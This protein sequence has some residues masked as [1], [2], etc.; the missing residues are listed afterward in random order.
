MSVQRSLP[1]S[2]EMAEGSENSLL[3]SEKKKG[4]NSPKKSS[5]NVNMSSSNSAQQKSDSA[6]GYDNNGLL[7]KLGAVYKDLN[8]SSTPF[9]QGSIYASSSRSAS[10]GVG[11]SGSA[12]DIDGSGQDG[13]S[14]NKRNQDNAAHMTEAKIAME[15]A[16]K[17]KKFAEEAQAQVDAIMKR[18]AGV[19][20]DSN[21]SSSS[22]NRN[23]M[24]KVSAKTAIVKENDIS[25]SQSRRGETDTLSKHKSKKRQQPTTAS[26]ESSKVKRKRYTWSDALHRKFMG[27]IFDI[28][29]RCA[30]PKLLL[31]ILQ[32]CP[33]GLTTEHIKSHLQKYRANSKK[34]RDM[35]YAQYEVAKDQAVKSHEGKALNPGFHAY[36]MPVGE[37]P[38]ITKDKVDSR[39][40]KNADDENDNPRYGWVYYPERKSDQSSQPR[41]ENYSSNDRGKKNERNVIDPQQKWRNAKQHQKGEGTDQT[42]DLFKQVKQMEDQVQMH[43]QIQ[44]RHRL[45]QHH[46]DPN[47]SFAESNNLRGERNP[48]Q[49]GS[50]H[51]SSSFIDP[52]LALRRNSLDILPEYEYLLSPL[53]SRSGH[54]EE[55]SQLLEE[56][57]NLF[58]FLEDI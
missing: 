52:Y 33:D 22:N 23:H 46:Y 56:D 25:Q 39:E 3:S 54:D 37:Y 50:G 5:K 36:P 4:S 57:N 20:T 13:M 49:S 21:V 12:R 15:V 2:Q 17:A 18:A 48:S 51:A 53:A 45:Q 24:G 19:N 14:G 7:E 9:T 10:G 42:L 6:V 26:S 30:K 29:L 34:T 58:K 41:D 44:E 1:F 47:S 55:N 28:G 11:G 8:V 32:P 38:P 43:Q 35:F 27:T 40:N 16:M 31:E